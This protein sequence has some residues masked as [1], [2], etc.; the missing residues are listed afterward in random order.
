MRLPVLQIVSVLFLVLLWAVV[1][2]IFESVLLP[3]PDQVFA[4][5]WEDIVSGE[6]LKHMSITIWRVVAAFVLAMSLGLAAGFTMGRSAFAD[7]LG[8]P[9]LIVFLNMPALVVIILAYMWFGLTEAAAIGAVAFNK[10]PHV[11]VTIREG[12][13]A[14]DPRLDE[15][16]D[17][18]RFGAWKRLRHVTLPQ[19]QPY[20]AAAARSGLSLIWKIVLVVEMLG[21]SSG[22]GFQLYLFFQLFD[23]AQIL[24]YSLSFT[25]IMLFIELLIVQP[26]ER[27][28]TRWR[29]RQA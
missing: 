25:L 13:R 26:Y 24:A 6:L 11:A 3:G 17:V 23:V 15:M 21:R 16:A 1:A 5:L 12:A 22:I 19:L 14:L 8:D 4:V 20:I 29:L 2:T 28:A 7:K 9:W 10:I 27:Y 18:Y